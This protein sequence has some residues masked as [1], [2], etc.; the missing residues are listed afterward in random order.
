MYHQLRPGNLAFK[1]NYLPENR[2]CAVTEI[3]PRTWELIME[4]WLPIRADCDI[5]FIKQTIV[6]KLNL[7]LIHCSDY[8]LLQ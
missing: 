7:Q 2:R 3:D 5:H 8:V 6:K 1:V 4:R